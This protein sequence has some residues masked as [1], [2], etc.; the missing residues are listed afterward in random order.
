MNGNCP[1]AIDAAGCHNNN[2]TVNCVDGFAVF[3]GFVCRYVL[4]QES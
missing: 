2:Y 1:G 3:D 4:P